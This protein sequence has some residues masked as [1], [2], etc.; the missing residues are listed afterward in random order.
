MG[1]KMIKKMVF[2]SI[3]SLATMSAFTQQMNKQE[4]SVVQ[5]D[6]IYI[7]SKGNQLALN[8]ITSENIQGLLGKPINVDKYEDEWSDE[9]DK[10]SIYEYNLLRVHF[11]YLENAEWLNSI[12]CS[13]PNISVVVNGTHLCVGEKDSVLSVFEK[14]WEQYQDLE[15]TEYYQDMTQKGY[16][17]KVLI[18]EFPI[19]KVD[20]EYLGSIFISIKDGYLVKIRI[21]LQDEA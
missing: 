18:L 11:R 14:S 17:E 15:H 1:T 5:I 13:N 3:L 9:Y 2:V 16:S 10:G 12:E 20:Y 21:S 8:N 4:Y 19:K 7:G 6:S